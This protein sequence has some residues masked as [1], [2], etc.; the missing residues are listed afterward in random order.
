MIA[1]FDTNII[2]DYLNGDERAR[3]EMLL[4]K[5][6]WISIITYIEVLVG[7]TNTDKYKVIKQYLLS[8]NI[9]EIDKDIADNAIEIRKKFK[10]KVPDALIL[11]SAE[12]IGA[13]LV[14]R[15]TKDF[16]S[17]LPFVRCPYVV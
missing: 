10:L 12:K 1:V 5:K 3:S 2:I 8:L 7:V 14:T 17:N 16:D 4:Y 11:A 9:L 13:I 15:N 6:V